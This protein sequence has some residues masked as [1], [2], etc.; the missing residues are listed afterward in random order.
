MPFE[1][2]GMIDWWDV[3][4]NGLWILGLAIVLAAFSYRSAWKEHKPGNGSML[5]TE[6]IWPGIGSWRCS[7]LAWA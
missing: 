7:V 4:T 2:R 5:W 6:E 1:G 3:F